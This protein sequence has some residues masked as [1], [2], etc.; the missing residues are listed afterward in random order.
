MDHDYTGHHY[1]GHNY[2]MNDLERE[3]HEA[4]TW[5]LSSW[6][7]KVLISP[8]ELRHGSEVLCSRLAVRCM[9]DFGDADSRMARR[10]SWRPAVPPST[11]A[12]AL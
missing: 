1:I 10:D 12:I 2:T 5:S 4:T 9:D 6:L 7:G 8:N 3:D 11:V